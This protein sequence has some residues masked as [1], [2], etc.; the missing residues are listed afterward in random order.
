[1]VIAV[2]ILLSGFLLVS[3]LGMV[4]PPE[5]VRMNSVNFKN[6]LQWESP[7]FPKGNLTYTAQFLSYNNFQDKCNS[8][9]L[10]ECDFSSI[11]KY[12]DHTL[13]V[14][15]EYA[16]EHSDWVVITFC[17]VD[18][19]LIGPPEVKVEVVADSLHLRFLAPKVVGEPETWTMRNIYPSWV[20]NVQYWKNGTEKELPVPV[21]FDAFTLQNLEPQTI[22]C[23]RAQGFLADRGKGG[24]WSQP[25]CEETT[26]DETISAWIIAVILIASVLV[27]S[28]L[29]VGCFVLMCYIYK[30]TKYTFAPGNSLPQHLKEF[31]NSP[32]HSTQLFY[33]LP[34]SDENEVFDKLSVITEDLENSQQSAGHSGSLRSS[35]ERGFLEPVSEKKTQCSGHSQLLVCSSASED[36]QSPTEP[37][38]PEQTPTLEPMNTGLI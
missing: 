21:K 22:Y 12:G 20:Y 24:E 9:T 34:P 18:D 26:Q 16:N 4:P 1:M 7:A 33:S 36:N 28:L 11:S 6:I 29:L 30:K 35:S 13:R 25:V 37:R 8:T 15:S 3:A 5:N 32:H 2:Q 14:R 19:T 31:L 38:P 27:V 10:T 17:P 23:V